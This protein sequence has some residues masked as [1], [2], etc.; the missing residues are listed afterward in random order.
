MIDFL[1]GYAPGTLL[2]ACVVVACVR[3]LKKTVLKNYLKNPLIAFLPFVLG[4]AVYAIYYCIVALSFDV[5]WEEIGKAVGQ[6]FA[7]GCLSTALS[8]LI[9]KHI[10]KT[11]LSGKAGIVRQLLEGIAPAETLDELAQRTA[12]NISE[13]GEEDEERVFSLLSES[14]NGES[15]TFSSAELRVLAKL[16]VAAVTKTT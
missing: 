5:F 2:V 12:D 11:A 6:G 7:V 1:A 4:V 13:G 3:L 14:L 10:G 9:D 15:E 8:A 16:I